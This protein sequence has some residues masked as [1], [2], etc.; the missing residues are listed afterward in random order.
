MNVFLS[1]RVFGIYLAG[2]A[3]LLI[4]AP[5]LILVSFGFEPAVDVW[6]R[7]LGVLVAILSYYYLMAVRAANV[8]MIRWSVPARI[9]AFVAF[10]LF[11]VVGWAQPMLILFGLV[12]LA[13]ALWTWF[14]LRQQ[15]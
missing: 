9:G 6:P 7:V 2:L 12:D 8:E 3:V 14:A 13:A 4:L 15:A 11:V 5:N 10:V 1:M